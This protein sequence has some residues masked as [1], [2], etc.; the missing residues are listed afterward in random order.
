MCEVA[1]ASHRYR[2]FV[3]LLLSQLF[4]LSIVHVDVFSWDLKFGFNRTVLF[5]CSNKQ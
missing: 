4:M 2:C 3:I 1:A 5:G